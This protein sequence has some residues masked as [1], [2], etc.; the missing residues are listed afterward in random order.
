M[1]ELRRGEV[2]LRIP[3]AQHPQQGE[4]RPVDMGGPGKTAVGRRQG[5]D[6]RQGKMILIMKR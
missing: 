1:G 6:L 5:G 4:G 2:Q 3:D